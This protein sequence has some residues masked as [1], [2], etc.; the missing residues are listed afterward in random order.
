MSTYGFKPPNQPIAFPFSLR[1]ARLFAWGEVFVLIPMHA[2]WI[3][4]RSTPF[5]AENTASA[6]VAA[7]PLVG[8]LLAGLAAQL[9]RIR[10]AIVRA[11]CLFHLTAAAGLFVLLA[12]VTVR[13][14]FSP[15]LPITWPL[16]FWTVCMAFALLGD[17]ALHERLRGHAG[18]QPRLPWLSGIALAIG[19]W[20]ALT[21]LASGMAWAP[22]FWTVSLVFHAVMASHS[23]RVPA[24]SLAPARRLQST[25]A[26]AESLFMAS[27]MLSAFFRLIFTCEMIG[28]YELKY[29]GFVNIAAN[30]LFVLGAA[31]AL[32]AGRFRFAFVTHAAIAAL[33]M[34]TGQESAWPIALVLGYGF[35]ALFNAST[36][37]SGL[38]WALA[39]PAVVFMWAFG[40]L[41]FMVAGVIVEYGLGL[42]LVRLL[43]EKLRIV[44]PALYAAWLVF[45]AAALLWPRR[46]TGSEGTPAASPAAGPVAGAM[47]YSAAWLVILV[48]ALYIVATTMWPPVFFERGE[49]M[50]VG[51]PSGVCHAGYSRSDEEYALLQ[52]LGVR[53]MR[54]DFHWSTAQKGPE[55]W[56][57]SEFD[58][59]LDA[60]EKHNVNVL[61]LLVFD[62][63]AIETNAE[64][65]KRD[66]YIAPED[67][68]L[69]LEY[70]RRT[71]TRY[72]GRVYAWELWNEPNLSRFW[73]GPRDELYELLR[74][75]AETVR[76]TDPDALLVGSA[77]SGAM[78]V[79]SAPGIEGLHA[80]GALRPVNH[81]AMHAYVSEP[82]TYYNEFLRVQ[83]AAA[84]YGHPGAVWITE[85]GD[86]DG[87]VYPWR[88]SRE[89]L[90]VHAM[91]AYT[92][93]TCLGIEKLVW[94][95]YQDAH[96]E[97]LQ[98]KPRD[99]EGFFG[100][101]NRDGTWKPAA[102]AYNLFSKHC[103]NSEIR[104]D[105]V[106][107]SGG[108][109]ARQLRT[110]LYRRDNGESALVIWFEP[111]LRP[112]A[113]ARVTLDLGAI[114][115]PAIMHSIT[116]GDAKPVLDK[117]IDLTETPTFLTFTAAG[118]ESAIT[119]RA[120]SS[121]ADAAWL[122]LALG[123]VAG[124]A[125]A[126]V[127]AKSAKA[128]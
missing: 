67:I 45:G 62:N 64:G 2:F 28:R 99:S 92:I 11:E 17:T 3:L 109:A 71:V 110:A 63:N 68:P 97:S 84:K 35:A 47:A 37:L 32:V 106:D 39:L 123:F 94:Y 81:P 114:G 15:G 116:D 100:L 52:A 38:S 89:H 82:R 33:F 101:T 124:G 70:I 43:T 126:A 88:G 122:L 12:Y 29:V 42:G 14:P 8:L 4:F 98:N 91:K 56:D 61:A 44:T 119:L 55:T 30:P 77:M 46:K 85:L 66:H 34:F 20:A 60:A 1:A 40:M 9:P 74:R 118:A 7:I 108:L 21:W 78:G 48:P 86:P 95:C 13:D 96:L 120:V 22:Y 57:F 59:Y 51:E 115:E 90:A 6:M 75:S 36:R 87:G 73:D 54:T 25:A 65:A 93:A 5:V 76:E 80:V 50:A 104:T 27:L 49:R 125:C 53:L 18:T 58:S 83:N 69:F 103:S 19:A 10:A 23:R 16:S 72:K 41:G 127:R 105:L 31:V 121:P 113:H 111:G 102:C 112:G 26:L 107:V 79:D 128:V 24:L 117:V